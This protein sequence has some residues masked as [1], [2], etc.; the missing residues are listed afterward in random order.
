MTA[1]RTVSRLAYAAAF[2]AALTT[3]PA[4]SAD[5]AQ[6]VNGWEISSSGDTYINAQTVLTDAG[7]AM[8]LRKHKTTGVSSILHFGADGNPLPAYP[9]P[10]NLSLPA[11]PGLVLNQFLYKLVP[12]GGSPA[13]FLL[14][15]TV[16]LGS[17][18]TK[19]G[20]C[21]L[22]YG[23]GLSETYG[24]GGFLEMSTSQS[25]YLG[26]LGDQI[27]TASGVYDRQGNPV[28]TYGT[29]GLP[30]PLPSGVQESSRSLQASGSLLLT[31]RTSS[32]APEAYKVYLYRI[33]PEG[34]LDSQ[35]A[36]GVLLGTHSDAG[37]FSICA[38]IEYGGQFFFHILHTSGKIERFSIDPTTGVSTKVG[39]VNGLPTSL[40]WNAYS[41][42]TMQTL[43]GR[44]AIIVKPDTD[45]A[46]TFVCLNAA[47]TAFTATALPNVYPS[48]VGAVIMARM[49]VDR[50]VF[51]EFL[52]RKLHSFNGDYSSTWFRF[53]GDTDTDGDGIADLSETGTGVFNSL[54]DTGSSST[55][56]DTDGDGLSDLD[57]VLLHGS[58]PSQSDTDGDGFKDGFEVASGFSP[59]NVTSKPAV[60]MKAVIAVELTIATRVGARYRIES[61]TDLQTWTDTGIRVDGT[62]E[63]V[64]DI[65]SRADQRARY[66]RAVEEQL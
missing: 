10:I 32:S 4:A 12:L 61:S 18:I 57:E 55:S 28:Y 20:Y 24:I 13:A 26:E 29:L 14:P 34:H 42:W 53:Q 40:P 44:L 3:T 54:S 65:F 38:P 31:G 49:R 63:E 27:Y 39:E 45:A 36:D 2:L 25:P 41:N 48:H 33:T 66:W 9:S 17:G 30:A 35:F 47:F 11:Y 21:K 50:L 59:T 16:Q 37:L 46:G 58:N 15:C 23:H 52:L 60:H 7:T 62:G 51:P 1:Q 56:S 43:D 6:Q 19:D 8:L 64:R 22:I 5:L